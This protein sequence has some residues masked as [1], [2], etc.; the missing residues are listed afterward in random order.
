MELYGHVF[1][2][3]GERGKPLVGDVDRTEYL[4]VAMAKV[5]PI[6]DA[7]DD[8]FKLV[9]LHLYSGSGTGFV[10]IVLYR[11]G[12]APGAIENI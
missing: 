9:E 8:G 1:T 4:S 7:A 2:T 10:F 3:D 12:E 6:A 11:L 5:Q